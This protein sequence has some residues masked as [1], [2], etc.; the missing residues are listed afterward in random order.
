MQ[1]SHV[2]LLRQIRLFKD[3]DEV[4]LSKPGR[5]EKMGLGGEADD[6]GEGGEDWTA[7]SAEKDGMAI[8]A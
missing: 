5:T 8:T 1:P 3:S 7:L 2:D 6:G 4:V